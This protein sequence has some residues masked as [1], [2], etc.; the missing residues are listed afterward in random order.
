M[1]DNNH[2]RGTDALKWILTK[3]KINFRVL[4]LK[5][6]ITAAILTKV[7]A[8]IANKKTI[9]ILN[10]SVDHFFKFVAISD[11]WSNFSDTKNLSNRPS[12]IN[13]KI[14][15]QI[16][17]EWTPNIIKVELHPKSMASVYF[18]TATEAFD[19]MNL[20]SYYHSHSN[21]QRI[22]EIPIFCESGMTWQL[23]QVFD[24]NQEGIFFKE[25][26]SLIY[27]LFY[28]VQKFD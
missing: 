7:W 15:K 16:H 4:T 19:N 28:S 22:H 5:F 3:M 23:H 6:D 18:T 17:S 8:E 12:K 2:L 20:S 13:C 9:E 10:I 26:S 25:V 27:F 24:Y 21:Q 14:S 11:M 1:S